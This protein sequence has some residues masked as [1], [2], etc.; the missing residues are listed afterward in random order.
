[1]KVPLRFSILGYLIDRTRPATSQD[2]FEGLNSQYGRERQFNMPFI[3]NHL[4]SL[5]GV[6]IIEV[7][8]AVEEADNLILSYQVTNYGRSRGRYLPQFNAEN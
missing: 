5:R 4:D 6:G 2:V 7:V 8:D 3:E 1:M